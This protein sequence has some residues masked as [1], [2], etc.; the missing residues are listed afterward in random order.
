MLPSDC[1]PAHTD[2]D[3]PHADDRGANAR[4]RGPH[5]ARAPEPAGGGGLGCRR[6]RRPSPVSGGSLW[7]QGEPSL[8]IDDQG[9]P[10]WPSR[11]VPGTSPLPTTRAHHGSS[12]RPESRGPTRSSSRW[13]SRTCPSSIWMKMVISRQPMAH[14][15]SPPCPS[16][17]G[18]ASNSRQMSMGPS[19]MQSDRYDGACRLHREHERFRAR[20]HRHATTSSHMDAGR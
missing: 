13:A 8:D 10:C 20:C 17:I 11:T 2:D 18:P 6:T 15:I 3:R 14:G 19:S 5:V 7:S 1:P 4:S 12:M 9:R 16:G